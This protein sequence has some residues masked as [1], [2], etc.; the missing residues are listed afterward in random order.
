MLLLNESVKIEKTVKN[1]PFEK[2][3]FPQSFYH[4]VN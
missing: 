3:N 2:F 1:Q 4:H